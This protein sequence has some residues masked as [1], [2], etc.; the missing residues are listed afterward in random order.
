MKKIK[1][2]LRKMKNAEVK[3]RTISALAMACAMF[4]AKATPVFAVV[5]GTTIQNN[6]I[7]NF[8]KP[9]YVVVFVGLL[10][11]DFIKKNL[12]SAIIVLVIGGL[13]GIFVFF[14][15]QV[16]TIISTVKGVVGL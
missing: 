5:D 16:E 9:I 12:A 1:K 15:D 6:L 2:L 8:V 4:M 13:V 14:P 10:V 3:S 11:K 7:N